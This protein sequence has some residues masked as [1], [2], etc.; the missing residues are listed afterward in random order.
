[1]NDR[2]DVHVV[3]RNFD[4]QYLTGF[5]GAWG[6]SDQVAQA[7]VFGYVADHIPEQLQLLKQNQGLW[8]EAVPIDPRERYETCDHCGQRMMSFRVY[9]DGKEYLCPD[10]R[11]SEPQEQATLQ[12]NATLQRDFPSPA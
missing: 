1:M 12:R 11:E 8:L 9:F 5:Q 3:I 7:K 6:F 4:G 2:H 10:C